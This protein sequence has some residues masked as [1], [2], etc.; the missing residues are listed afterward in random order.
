VIRALEIVGDREQLALTLGTRIALLDCWLDDPSELP[1]E[2][3]LRAVDLCW[4]TTCRRY[5]ET[6]RP[7]TRL[8]RRRNEE[9]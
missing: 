5:G 9:R 6:H 4:I 8:L 3:Y 2:Y 7:V 1:D